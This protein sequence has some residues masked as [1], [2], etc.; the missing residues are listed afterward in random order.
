M[1][2]Q[3][4]K[5]KSSLGQNFLTDRNILG[6]I[7]KWA[8][9][10]ESDILL[11]I[12]AGQGVLTRELALSPCSRIFALEIDK[13]LHT[14][15]DPLEEEFRPR[16]SIIWDDA[17]TFD[18]ET[19]LPAA[20]TKV[21]ANIPYNITTPLI[22]RLLEA[23]AGKG[24]HSMIL[25]VQREAALRLNASPNTKDRYPLGITLEI[26]GER[27]I[28]RKVPPQAFYPQPAVDSAV[29]EIKVQRNFDL[30]RQKNW[31][32]LLR[33][34]FAQRR[35][36]L[37]NSASRNGVSKNHLIDAFSALHFNPSLRAENLT[38]KQW[39]ELWHMLNSIE[40]ERGPF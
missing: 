37:I 3:T 24:L 26:M 21:V 22:W 11:E 39:L 15:L 4:F 17:V 40:K 34:S 35:K 10:D 33:A 27:K 19:K 28:L 7:V 38:G 13:T 5:H 14:H 18:Y 1:K 31:R 12:G 32:I 30:P 29:I 2:D 23:F 8:A 36:T 25:M 9:I 20:P 6:Q 16:L